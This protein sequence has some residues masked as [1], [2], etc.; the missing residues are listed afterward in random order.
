MVP[1]FFFFKNSYGQTFLSCAK[2]LLVWILLGVGLLL[3]V[4]FFVALW[5]G[6]KTLRAVD[7]EDSHSGR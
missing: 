4:L 7:K 1:A 2:L 6:G 3:V 5:Y